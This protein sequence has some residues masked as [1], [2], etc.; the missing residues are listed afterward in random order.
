[1]AKKIDL[2]GQRFS[3]LTVVGEAGRSRG[4]VMWECLCDC[5]KKTAVRGES[6]RGG[7]TRSCGCLQREITSAQNKG[8]PS[9]RRVGAKIAEHHIWLTRLKRGAKDR[10]LPVQIDDQRLIEIG[11]QNCIYCGAEPRRVEEAKRAYQRHAAYQGR[12][13]DTTY[14]DSDPFYTNG[15]DRIDSS[16]GYIEDNCVP[17]CEMCN[18]MKLDHSAEEWFAHMRK[19]LSFQE[20]KKKEND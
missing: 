17:C 7:H 20:N 18:T 12:I 19:V 1:M 2:I 6:L 4:Q 5:G 11:S 14:Y 9:P 13:S 8:K 16:K 15:I 3:R 10:S